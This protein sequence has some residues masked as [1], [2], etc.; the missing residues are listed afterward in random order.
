MICLNNYRSQ[1]KTKNHF[2]TFLQFQISA[3]TILFM[4]NCCAVGYA[5]E[6]L[7]NVEK[8]IQFRDKDVNHD[9]KI[10]H[11]EFENF[12]KAIDKN[13]DGL[14]SEKEYTA[15]WKGLVRPKIIK[16]AFALED[17][18]DSRAIDFDEENF[19]F[20][21]IDKDTDQIILECEFLDEFTRY[22]LKEYTAETHCQ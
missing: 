12:H 5:V 7:T 14:V 15:H 10:T 13:T 22:V 21:S 18:D 20:E 3:A 16:A 2:L 19:N 4:I 8:L 11:K 6:N 9:G 1:L 17:L